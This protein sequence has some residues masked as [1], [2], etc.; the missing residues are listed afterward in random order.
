[1]L[2]LYHNGLSTCS[3][4]VRMAL[5]EAGLEYQSEVVDLIGG[6]QHDPEYVKLNPKHVVPTLVVDGTVIRE[7]TII[8]EYIAGSSP[9]ADLVPRD[10][11]AASKM[12]M[13]VKR[14]DD[15]I[16]GKTSGVFTHSLW[17]RNIMGGRSA[18]EKEAYFA[19]IPDAAERDLRRSILAD[20]V[21][22]AVYANAVERIVGLFNELELALGGKTWLMGDQ[23]TLADMSVMPYVLRTSDAAM[24]KMWRDGRRPN[25]AAWFDRI[26][27]RASYGPAVTD[28]APDELIS[29]LR[30]FGE[31]ERDAIEKV[32]DAKDT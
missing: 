3:Q 12:R 13:W 11:L 1:M 25:L 30:S 8:N 21:G 9:G 6:G 2:T 18:E 23:F 15:D 10:P 20:G 32:I 29:M 16:H 31:K 17:T 4:K 28:W 24:D 26:R 19:G 22:S 27:E 5:A 7:S 14:I